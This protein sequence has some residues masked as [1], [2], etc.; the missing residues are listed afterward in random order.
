MSSFHALF[1]LGGVAGALVASG[2]MSAGLDDVVHVVVAAPVALAAVGGAL[3]AMAD[4][5]AVYLRD[6]LHAA[7]ALAAGGFAGFSLAMA[8]GRLTGDV[9]VGRFGGRRVLRVSRAVAAGG[10]AVA[11]LIGHPAAGI[12]GCALVGL[13]I[14]NII[15]VLFSAT[16]RIPGVEPGRALSAVATTGY[17]GFLAGPPL[18]GGVAEAAGL[19]I[20]LGLVSVA[21]ALV[22]VGA[23]RLPEA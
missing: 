12:V 5:S 7:P 22:A 15:P 6:T 9:V 20:G 17:P 3:G 2:A 14:A 19:A 21:C 13:G 1:S 18:I 4:W 11:L 8:A 23:R 16:A 10:L